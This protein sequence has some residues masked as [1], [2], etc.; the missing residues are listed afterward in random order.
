[1]KKFLLLALLILPATL[2]AQTV[3]TGGGSN[4]VA[5]GAPSGSC[6]PGDTYTDNVTNNFYYCKAGVW[7]AITASGGSGNVSNSGTPLVHQNA[8]WVDA[9]HIK[10]IANGTTGQVWTANTG[11]D[12]GWGAGG[13]GHVYWNP[14]VCVA[15]GA[16]GVSLGGNIPATTP[17]VAAYSAAGTATTPQICGAA[18]SIANKGNGQWIEWHKVL[19]VAN[20]SGLV[21]FNYYS[22]AATSG[23]GF[24]TVL[25]AC[26]AA[27]ATYQPTYGS[28]QT[29][30]ASA[31]T[32][33]NNIYSATITTGTITCAAGSTIW[34]RVYLD[35]TTTVASGN[36]DLTDFQYVEQ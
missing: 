16:S 28:A 25:M 34:G 14:A 22:D 18:F 8:V 6:S 2:L 19:E 17:P 29:S 7:T 5:A 10:G 36:L 15:Q 20:P 33:I 9:T 21:T 27:G 4:I 24:W 26:G 31:V 23:N 32:A 30:S 3:V 1:M 12:P 13:S 11:A 35:S